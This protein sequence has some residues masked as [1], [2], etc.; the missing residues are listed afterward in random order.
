MSVGRSV[1]WFVAPSVSA[2]FVINEETDKKGLLEICLG[3]GKG[4]IMEQKGSNKGAGSNKE[5]ARE[6]LGIGKGAMW[7]REVGIKK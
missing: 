5:A 3:S 1:I 7:E 2:T 4:A 6:Q